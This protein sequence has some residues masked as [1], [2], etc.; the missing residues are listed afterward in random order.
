MKYVVLFAIAGLFIVN[1][2][3]AQYY[4]MVPRPRRYR[5]MPIKRPDPFKPEV[6]LSVGYGFP[7]LDQ[8]EFFQFYNFY[9]GDVNQ[10]GPVWGS[11]DYR[12]NRYTSVGATVAYGK[13]SAPF[14][15]FRSAAPEPPAFTGKMEDWTVMFNLVRYM[16]VNKTV[17]PYLKTAIGVNLWTQ[18]YTDSTGINVVSPNA[19]KPSMLAYQASLGVK[20][21]I[22]KGTGLFIEAGYGKYILGAGLSFKF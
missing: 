13:V 22:D 7:N 1:T 11:L 14:Y 12:F 20:F 18:S 21:N 3:N 4:R 6:T 8:N 17:E 9:R 16:P 10:T 2:S 15:D 5:E 19:E